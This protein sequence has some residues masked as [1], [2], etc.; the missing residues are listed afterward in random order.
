M[1]Y[2]E[3]L[4]KIFLLIFYGEETTVYFTSHRTS[5]VRVDFIKKVKVDAV[6]SFSLSI[7]LV[8]IRG[9]TVSG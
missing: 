2:F 9:A 3:F 1:D 6:V 7:K 8:F 5:G 4:F